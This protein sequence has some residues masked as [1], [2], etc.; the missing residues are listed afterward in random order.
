MSRARS[1]W[2]VVAT[3]SAMEFTVA[4]ALGEAGYR[5]FVPVIR[6]IVRP[7]R[8][9]AAPRMLPMLPGY[10]F[11][12]EWVGWP[13]Q[14]IAGIWGILRDAAGNPRHISDAD[15]LALRRH[16]IE[17]D[18]PWPCARR[19]VRTDLAIGDEVRI[20]LGGEAIPARIKGLSDDGKAV[21]TAML[22]GRET[23]IA[24][25]EQEEIEIA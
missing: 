15:V 5:T 9:P 22:F 25:V 10:L 2:V 17:R 3:R 13:K 4:R 11:A 6:R 18:E 19:R 1:D 8:G 7:H 12:Q 14:V 16:Q 20:D 23:A 21:V 24:G